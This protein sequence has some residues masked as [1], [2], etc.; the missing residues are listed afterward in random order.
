LKCAT[1]SYL[2][3][4]EGEPIMAQGRII[5]TG[6]TFTI[7]VLAL[8]LG[9]ALMPAA[10]QTSAAS[11]DG[12]APAVV[13]NT[14]TTGTN[15]LT[16][17]EGAAVGVIGSNIYVVGGITA[18]YGTI[19][20]VNEIYN[21]KKKTWTTG[22]PLPTPTCY[23][24]GAV[25]NGILYVIGGSYGTGEY[26]DTVYAY[27]PVSNTWSTMAPMPTA[28]N[29]LSAVV[30]KGIIYVIGGYSGSRDTT[31]ESY[32]PATN[33]WSEEAP[34]L[35]GKSTA[36]VGLLGGKILSAGGL[37]NSGLTGDNEGYNVKKNEWTELVADPTV[38]DASCAWTIGTLFH[39]AGGGLGSGA[40]T[41]VNEAYS[42]KTNSWTT[43]APMPQDTGYPGSAVVGGR[44]YCL[45]GYS[46]NT[47]VVGAVQIYQP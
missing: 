33:T 35:V 16:P 19:L 42:T 32:D 7:A 38:R 22:A 13:H 20:S 30:D 2:S 3:V 45:G 39:V 29:S 27:D 46:S 36:N 24:V 23:T 41:T 8:A 18:P 40:T 11:G 26:T 10:A 15:M 6:N 9:T 47:G 44:L 25:V 17:R 5:S 14:W 37:S 31:V 34:L 43:L 4:V 12:S 21:T 1:D 28:R